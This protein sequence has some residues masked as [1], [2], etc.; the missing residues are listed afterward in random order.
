MTVE[1]I[2][3]LKTRTLSTNLTFVGENIQENIHH[4]NNS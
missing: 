4:Q 2:Y 1:M 3:L